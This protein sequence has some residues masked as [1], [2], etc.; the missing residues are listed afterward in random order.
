[1]SAPLDNY[2]SIN[3]ALAQLACVHSH[4][5]QEHRRWPESPDCAGINDFIST[6]ND[7]QR[8]TLA[9]LLDDAY[10]A[11]IH[12]TL[13]FLNDQIASHRLRLLVN[14]LD[15]PVT[16]LGTTLH[17]DYVCRRQGDPWPDQ[18]KAIEP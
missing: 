12:D 5:V 6:L 8:Q 11:G 1:M 7:A 10:S 14:D 15:L 17:W 4:W 9:R 3:D 2:K 18:P 16:P 13:A